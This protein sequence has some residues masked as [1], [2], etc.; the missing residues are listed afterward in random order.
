MANSRPA[1]SKTRTAGDLTP[2]GNH[3]H[4]HPPASTCENDPRS[5]IAPP[6]TTL[7]RASP[8]P[9]TT[10]GRSSA[11]SAYCSIAKRA[12]VTSLPSCLTSTRY[13]PMGQPLVGLVKEPVI[14]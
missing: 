6:K 8:T 4:A 13:L 14:V 7:G 2:P 10:L 1:M 11:V 12:V 5:T 9:K 3:S